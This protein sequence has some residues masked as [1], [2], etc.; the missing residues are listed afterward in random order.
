MLIGFEAQDLYSTWPR[1]IIRESLYWSTNGIGRKQRNHDHGKLPKNDSHKTAPFTDYPII[2][3]SATTKQRIFKAVEMAVEVY[4]RKNT[5]ITTS[6][7]NN[8][9][10]PIIEAT[11]PAYKG[12]Y[13]RIKYITQIP[14][15]VPS[16][17]FFCNLPQYVK[18]P[19]KRFIE[20][21]FREMYDL[22]ESQFEFISEKNKI[23][24]WYIYRAHQ[25]KDLSPILCNSN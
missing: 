12:K 23:L 1:R 13:V 24:F 6:E 9:F 8:T 2:F 18:D 11:P 10:L 20:N 15:K 19:Y 3:I 22:T 16:F 7:L 14:T 17:A 4:D 5:K 21:K 25:P